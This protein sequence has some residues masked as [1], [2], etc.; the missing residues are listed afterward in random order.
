MKR[1]MPFTPPPHRSF[2]LPLS[3]SNPD[4]HLAVAL[5]VKRRKRW[6]S[7]INE[8]LPEDTENFERRKREREEER[9]RKETEREERRVKKETEARSKEEREAEEKREEEEKLQEA[10]LGV[11]R[12]EAEL[13]EKQ[14]QKKELF[15]LLKQVIQAESKRK[16]G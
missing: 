4:V 13:E 8:P 2:V 10:S 3:P 1:A 11:L 12:T 6:A 5:S 14:N 9:I 15:W 7:G 16:K